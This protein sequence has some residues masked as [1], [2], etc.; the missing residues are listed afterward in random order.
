GT[1]LDLEDASG[2]AIR[3]FLLGAWDGNPDKNYLAYRTPLGKALLHHRAGDVIQLPD[4]RKVTLKAISALP[5]DVLAE[6]E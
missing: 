3:Y 2:K 1:V 4:G 6:M 5:A